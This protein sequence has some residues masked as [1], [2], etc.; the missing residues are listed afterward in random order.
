MYN[1]LEIYDGFG[2]HK[3][4]TDNNNIKSAVGSSHYASKLTGY[5]IHLF[6]VYSVE[7][8]WS[9]GM[10]DFLNKKK[11]VNNLKFECGFELKPEF[12]LPTGKNLTNS[13]V[14]IIIRYS[15]WINT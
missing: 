9:G 11:P 12:F 1:V 4:L 5:I 13:E 8:G 3:L 2:S 14:T 7:V 15:H 10:I 6:L